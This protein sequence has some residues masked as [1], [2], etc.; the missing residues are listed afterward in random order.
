[1]TIEP[2]PFR[3]PLTAYEQQAADLLSAF[4]A[5]DEGAVT[6]VG[7]R[8]PRF[9]RDDV[10]WAPKRLTREQVQQAPFDEF[11]ARLTLA[12]WYD[13][14][15]WRWLRTWVL[16]VQDETSPVGRFESAVEAIVTGD[17]ATLTSLLQAHPDLVR[18]R[19]TRVNSFDPPMHRATLLHYIAANGVETYRQKTPPNDVAIARV[20]LDA[21]AD[22]DAF[23]DMYGGP[24]TTM[25][26]L[27]SS[28]PPN[29]A[30]LQVALAE[31]LL[32]YGAAIDGHHTGTWN[33]PLMT[34]L[35][36]GFVDTAQMLARRGAR[37]DT[38]AAAAGL[39]RIDDVRRLLPSAGGDDR[40]RALALAALLGHADVVGVLLDA[41]EDP[42][43]FNPQNL[44]A[45]GT[46]LHHAAC[47]GHLAVVRLL[48]ER[49]AR[50]DVKD[51]L[52]ES[53][54]LGWAE[55]CGKP[56]VAEYLRS[57]TPRL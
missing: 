1:L 45:H 43:R 36:F 46:P 24:C 13:F 14:Q 28:T 32:D 55:Y 27:V 37:V 35:V 9:L 23:A 47:R 56:E 26:M 53:T 21:G 30:G 51:T 29:E 49:G 4:H 39:G 38:V 54:P 6:V 20:L 8:H 3:S 41:G 34:A 44:H 57:Q 2:L 7:N 42:S 50:L 15:D 33:N 40:H 17:I 5:G 52:W 25:S 31:T 22:V 11:D 16:A 48:V 10:P 12:R 18:A 19:S